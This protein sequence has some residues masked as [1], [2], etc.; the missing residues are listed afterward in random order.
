[1]QN[2]RL[3]GAGATEYASVARAFPSSELLL[4]SYLIDHHQASA[5]ST[6]I[7]VFTFFAF[8]RSP[9]IQIVVG[10]SILV[11]VQPSTGKELEGASK[12]CHNTPDVHIQGAAYGLNERNLGIDKSNVGRHGV[13]GHSGIAT[14]K[15]SLS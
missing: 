2:L 15:F 14:L 1:M 7:I 6:S 13:S 9:N 4:L 11:R 10:Q 8:V 3:A 12:S 5:T